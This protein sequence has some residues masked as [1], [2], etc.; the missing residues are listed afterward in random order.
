MVAFKAAMS[1]ATHKGDAPKAGELLH[2]GP[3]NPY[4]QRFAE[5]QVDDIVQPLS[6]TQY[7]EL[8]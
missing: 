1:A 2:S 5:T 7:G 4:A 8:P 3:R 6:G